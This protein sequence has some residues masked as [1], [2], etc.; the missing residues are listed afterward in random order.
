MLRTEYADPTIKERRPNLE[1]GCLYISI[2]GWRMSALPAQNRIS[3]RQSAISV[4][5]LIL[6]LKLDT[7][8][9]LKFLGGKCFMFK[10]LSESGC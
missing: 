6:L 4:E 10:K 5:L 7:L 9:M 1:C 8:K 2:I 3:T